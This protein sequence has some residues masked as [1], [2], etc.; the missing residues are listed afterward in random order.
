MAEH[1]NAPAGT[2]PPVPSVARMYDYYLEGK[3]NSASDREAAEKIISL[4]P[5]IGKVD[6][7]ALYAAADCA[8]ERI[9]TPVTSSSPPCAAETQKPTPLSGRSSQLCGRLDR[10]HPHTIRESHHMTR[11]ARPH[12]TEP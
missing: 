8:Q 1:E 5:N 4:V 12:L 7:V 2:N 10:R 11:W 3:D 9:D 6:W